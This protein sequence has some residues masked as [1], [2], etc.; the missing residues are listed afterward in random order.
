MPTPLVTKSQSMSQTEDQNS[1]GTAVSSGKEEGIL[2]VLQ[3]KSQRC[4]PRK[5]GLNPD[6][7]AGEVYTQVPV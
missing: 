4:Q 1:E 5:N 7:K 6:E 3:T 2:E